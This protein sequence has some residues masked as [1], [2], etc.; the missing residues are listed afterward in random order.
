MRLRR[1][2]EMVKLANRIEALKMKADDSA[3]LADSPHS[4]NP[5]ASASGESAALSPQS[6]EGESRNRASSRANRNPLLSDVVMATLATQR[7]ERTLKEM[8]TRVGSSASHDSEN[9]TL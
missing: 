4:P 2:I 7:S 3:D 1:G 6:P 8:R 5:S 9:K